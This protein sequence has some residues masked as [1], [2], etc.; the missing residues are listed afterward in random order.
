MI[1]TT[2]IAQDHAADMAD[3]VTFI[4]SMGMVTIGLRNEALVRD[5]R[6]LEQAATALRSLGLA[7]RS[8][9]IEGLNGAQSTHVY[10]TN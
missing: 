10:R 9:W 3:R 7:P 1:A 8:A 4:P 2:L 5:V 6:T